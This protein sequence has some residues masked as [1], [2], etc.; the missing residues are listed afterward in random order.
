MRTK[1]KTHK[2]LN[3]LSLD[4]EQQDMIVNF[5]ISRYFMFKNN[6]GEKENELNAIEK[7]F[8]K[9]NNIVAKTFIEMKNIFKKKGKVG[10]RQFSRNRKMNE[11]K[12]GNI[13]EYFKKT[14]GD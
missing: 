2:S 5:S 12:V 6:K 7:R 9:D 13:F 10:I 1:Q 14:Y 11:K 8:C 4:L 3:K